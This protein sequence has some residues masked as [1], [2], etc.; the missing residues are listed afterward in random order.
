MCDLAQ[1]VWLSVIVYD[2]YFQCFLL[3][4][5]SFVLFIWVI[6]K[7]INWFDVIDWQ[8]YKWWCLRIDY[9]I[10]FLLFLSSLRP[11]L[12]ILYFSHLIAQLRRNIWSHWREEISQ[13]IYENC[14]LFIIFELLLDFRLNNSNIRY[15]STRLSRVIGRALQTQC[16]FSYIPQIMILMDRDWWYILLIDSIRNYTK[17]YGFVDTRMSQTYRD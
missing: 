8:S 17:L 12:R 2:F 4:V 15:G 7:V 13:E 9:R 11:L 1:P 14:I 3:L 5:R 6:R 16:E 10:K